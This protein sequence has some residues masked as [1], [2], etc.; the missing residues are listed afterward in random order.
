MI[1]SARELAPWVPLLCAVFAVLLT[2][3][4]RP[5][6][7]AAVGMTFQAPVFKE[8]ERLR[9]I[10]LTVGAAVDLAAE[11]EDADG[12]ELAVAH[13]AWCL[14]HQSETKNGE[15]AERPQV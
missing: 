9:S 2:G 12:E 8:I 6:L 14:D 5:E 13:F 15:P 11:R 7:I 10:G 4:S 3:I 1:V